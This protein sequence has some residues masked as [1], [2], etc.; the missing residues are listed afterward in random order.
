MFY[1]SLALGDRTSLGS[2]II[3]IMI[4]E[5]IIDFDLNWKFED[6]YVCI[7]MYESTFSLDLIKCCQA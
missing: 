3:I 7:P 5:L 6:E 1:L 4:I 2:E